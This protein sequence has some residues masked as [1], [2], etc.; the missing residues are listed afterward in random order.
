MGKDIKKRK[1]EI[2]TDKQTDRQIQLKRIFKPKSD[3]FLLFSL[4]S[5][6]KLTI[7]NK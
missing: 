1:T 6:Q 7:L 5:V 2:Q 3:T 4:F